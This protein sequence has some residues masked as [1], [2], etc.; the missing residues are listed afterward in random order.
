MTKK[1]KQ[2]LVWFVSGMVVQIIAQIMAK[3]NYMTHPVLFCIAAGFLILVAVVVG[4]VVAGRDASIHEE[5]KP[6]SYYAEKEDTK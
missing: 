1:C 5:P 4:M 6:Y 2:S 3:N